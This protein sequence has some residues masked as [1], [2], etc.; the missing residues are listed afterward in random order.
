MIHP[1][2]KN[3]ARTE[4]R[5]RSAGAETFPSVTCVGSAFMLPAWLIWPH[6]A[7]LELLQASQA[8]FWRPKEEGSLQFNDPGPRLGSLWISEARETSGRPSDGRWTASRILARLCEMERAFKRRN[9]VHDP[10]T[11]DVCMLRPRCIYLLDRGHGVSRRVGPHE[12]SAAAQGA[13][14]ASWTSIDHSRLPTTRLHCCTR[15]PKLPQLTLLGLWLIRALCFV[16]EWSSHWPS[17]SFSG[18]CCFWSEQCCWS[19]PSSC[20][21]TRLSR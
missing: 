16:C 4:E 13:A 5:N 18:M 6:G 8:A 21:S 19:R 20:R 10:F 3:A 11:L 2:A 7:V 15:P 17:R 14:F 9:T 1:P 12:Y